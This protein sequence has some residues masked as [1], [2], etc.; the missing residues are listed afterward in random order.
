[1]AREGIPLNDRQ[2]VAA[3]GA[4]VVTL[5]LAAMSGCGGE[6]K[7]AAQAPVTPE[8]EKQAEA[9]SNYLMDQMKKN[10]AKK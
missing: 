5:M 8:M 6:D 7:N 1:M 4:G 10:N 3:L 2:R 9:S